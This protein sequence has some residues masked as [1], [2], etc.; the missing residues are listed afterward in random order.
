MRNT[1]KTILI[2]SV[3]VIVIVVGVIIL[4]ITS[5][6]RTTSGPTAVLQVVAGENF[7][8]SLVSQIGGTHVH[9]MSI[10]SDP[11]ADPH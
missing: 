9:V 5:K 1:N 10:V 6:G 4:F 7:W 11:N 2:W 8:G 3:A